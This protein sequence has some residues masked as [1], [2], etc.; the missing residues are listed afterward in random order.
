MSVSFWGQGQDS[1]DE[2]TVVNTSGNA[3]TMKS[4]DYFEGVTDMGCGSQ[5]LSKKKHFLRAFLEDP[6][7][8]EAAKKNENSSLASSSKKEEKHEI[9]ILAFQKASFWPKIIPLY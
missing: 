7:G 6:F 3:M 2:V 8:D 4:R 5:P 1:E 9:K